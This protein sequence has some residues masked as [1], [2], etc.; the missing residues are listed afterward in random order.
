MKSTF[1]FLF[2]STPKRVLK[3]TNYCL[4]YEP[5]HAVD[6]FLMNSCDIRVLKDAF[7]FSLYAWALGRSF[8]IGFYHDIR[9][10][11]RNL[12]QLCI[13]PYTPYI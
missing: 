5:F 6:K 12:H 10:S 8:P 13:V 1:F 9:F 4:G 7:A 3:S 2:E 11:L